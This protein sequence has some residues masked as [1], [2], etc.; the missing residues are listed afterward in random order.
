MIPMGMGAGFNNVVALKRRNRHTS[1]LFKAEV[2]GK[3]AIFCL[4]LVKLILRVLDQIHLID[5]NDHLFDSDQRH[6]IAMSFRLRQDPFAPIHQNNRNVCVGGTGCHVT[7]ILFMA[8]CVRHNKLTLIRGEE[9]IGHVNGDAL[10]AFRLQT[11][12]QQ[13]IVNI[14]ALGADFFGIRF[15]GGQLIFKNQ[16]GIPKQTPDQRA[17]AIIH[18]A[19]SDETQQA[20]IFLCM[21][22]L[23]NIF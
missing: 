6:D 23:Q 1:N 2:F 18:R 21:Q 11:I 19:T 12:Q 15:K 4:N 10:F 14:A 9:T 8:R 16:L 5:R 7:G 20:F 3:Q 13:R 17:F 22:V